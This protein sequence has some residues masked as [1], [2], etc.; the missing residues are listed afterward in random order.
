MKAMSET[1]EHLIHCAVRQLL[2][3]R[4]QGNRKAIAAMQGKRLY[5]TLKPLA[6]EQWAKGNRGERGDWR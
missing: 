3:W 5:E 4:A 2:R 1:H 6:E